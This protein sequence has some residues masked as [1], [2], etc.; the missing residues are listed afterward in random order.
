MQMILRI[1]VSS[2][3]EFPFLRLNILESMERVDRILVCEANFTHTGK[4]RELI[5]GELIEGLR[6]E[7]KVKVEYLPLKLNNLIDWSHESGQLY[8][9]IE[10]LIRNRFSEETKIHKDDIVIAVDADEVIYEASYDLIEKRL[11]KSWMKKSK[12]LRLKL[13]QF[14]Y[15]LDYHWINCEFSSPVAAKAGYFLSKGNAAQWRDEGEVSKF[16]AGCHFS[17]VMDV[18]QMLIKLQTYAH[19][20]IYGQFANKQLL[21]F[22]IQNKEYPFDSKVNFKVE[23]IRKTSN[24]YPNRFREVFEDN[25]PWFSR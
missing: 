15:K 10:R 14:F 19:N 7:E 8:H 24:I 9:H 1:L 25:H 16:F 2:P 5:F 6:R 21:E 13:H 22:A 18:D 4:E 17:W 20:D 3:H 23:E 12:S 11:Y